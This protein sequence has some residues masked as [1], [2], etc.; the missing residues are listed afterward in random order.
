M[1]VYVGD[2]YILVRMLHIVIKTDPAWRI[3]S[4]R[5]RQGVIGSS[6]HASYI[7]GGGACRVVAMSTV[8]LREPGGSSSLLR[9][10]DP[11]DVLNLPLY[12]HHLVMDL[13]PS[14][15]YSKGHMATAVS[16]LYS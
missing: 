2:Y 16:F 10:V 9:M 8:Q 1:Q 7:D 15:E 4:M 11:D 14:R 3:V 13:R 6:G 12:E 5:M